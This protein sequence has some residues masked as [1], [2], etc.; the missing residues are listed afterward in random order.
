MST[1]V[2]VW[3]GII[4]ANLVIGTLAMNDDQLGFKEMTVLKAMG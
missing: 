2:C 3:M 4:L 1:A